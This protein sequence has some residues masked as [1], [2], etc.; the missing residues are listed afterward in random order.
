M[1][2]RV[3]AVA[4]ETK[5]LEKGWKEASGPS[6]ALRLHY[7]SGQIAAAGCQPMLE[8][9]NPEVFVCRSSDEALILG[10]ESAHG[11]SSMYDIAFGTVGYS[12]TTAKD[13]ALCE[14]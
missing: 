11:A 6:Q 5:E 4:A 1:G 7:E 12:G 14:T 2:F 3:Q 9:V 13:K 10:V 8:D